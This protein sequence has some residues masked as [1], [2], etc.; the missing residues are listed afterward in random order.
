MG[1]EASLVQNEGGCRTASPRVATQN[2]GYIGIERA[3]FQANE[4]QRDVDRTLFMKCFKLTR[5]SNV[6]PVSASGDNFFCFFMAYSFGHWFIE[7]L[8]EIFFPQAHH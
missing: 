7:Q 1:L 8:V 6:E 4:I 2:V 5:Q 3:E